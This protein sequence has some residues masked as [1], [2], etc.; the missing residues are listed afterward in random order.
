MAAISKTACKILSFAPLAEGSPAEAALLWGD[1]ATGPAALLVRFPEGYAEPWHNHSASYRAV[2]VRGEFQS[3]S[4]DDSDSAEIYG[5]G[6][7]PV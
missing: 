3:R 1:P 7:F 6:A 2:L 5:P 4:Q